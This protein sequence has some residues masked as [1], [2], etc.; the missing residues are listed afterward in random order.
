VKP[1]SIEGCEKPMWTRGWCGMHYQR[2]QK[3]GNPLS[4]QVRGTRKPCSI[5]GCTKPVKARELC[6][7]HYWRWQKY[8]D[9]LKL[10]VRETVTKSCSVER[11]AKPMKAR[12]MCQMH[13]GR[14]RKHG[15]PSACS[16][17]WHGRSQLPEYACWRSMIARCENPNNVS[18]AN[19]GARGI[20]V[21]ERWHDFDAYCADMGSRPSSAHSIERIDNDG[22]Y[23]PGN[24]RWATDEEQGRNRR[25][26]WSVAAFGETMCVSEW[27][28]RTG[29]NHRTIRQR[30]STGWSAE[31]ALTALPERRRRKLAA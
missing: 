3:Y 21:C 29:I 6:G 16:V 8:G 18:Y 4:V 12:G 25:S 28:R 2:W 19:Y 5:D 17:V 11:C 24:C 23:E 27:A 22:D 10:H 15:D 1:C 30:L 20:R 14:W 13:Y 9:P 26:V 31:E 7:T